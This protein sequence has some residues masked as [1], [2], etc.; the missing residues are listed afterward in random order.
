MLVL[1]FRGVSASSLST[2][3]IW[4][5]GQLAD[6]PA[7][8]REVGGSSPP[9]PAKPSNRESPHD[10]TQSY[11]RIP[12]GTHSHRTARLWR[13]QNHGSAVNALGLGGCQRGRV[14]VLP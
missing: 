14:P 9:A 11:H 1:F 13:R 4:G 12:R 8:N 5:V 3:S 2:S 10:E 7:V 6:R